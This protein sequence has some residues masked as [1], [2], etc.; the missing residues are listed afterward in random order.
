MFILRVR[1]VL[2]SLAQS[3]RRIGRT[4]AQR[5]RCSAVE[6]GQAHEE[7]HA[8][9]RRAAPSDRMIEAVRVLL[10]EIGEDPAREGLIRTP[11]RYAKALLDLTSGY[12]ADLHSAA[13][14]H[15][16]RPPPHS[17]ERPG[18][19]PCAP[20]VAYHPAEIVNGAMFEERHH[21]LVL[22]RN[23]R[24]HSLCEHHILPFVGVAHV[25]YLPNSRV[26]GLSK[27]ARI[28]NMFAKRLQVQERM[29]AQIADTLAGVTGAHGVAVALEARCAPT[30]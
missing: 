3:G 29:G 10:E 13:A 5:S 16:L 9:A 22:V 7:H 30:P 21:E 2:P 19:R 24:F 17:A 4:G 26:I 15:V 28:T 8:R 25:A 20:R 14:P 12:H 27:V 18:N 11:K 1:A 23:I 6:P